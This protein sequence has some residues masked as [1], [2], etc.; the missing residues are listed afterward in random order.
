MRHNEY[1]KFSDS[2][3]LAIS[4]KSLDEVVREELMDEWEKE[5]LSWFPRTDTLS[6]AAY[7][8]REPGQSPCM[9]L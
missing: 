3:Y 2:L 1:F 7:D 9:Y 6:N 5:K 4:G 8:K